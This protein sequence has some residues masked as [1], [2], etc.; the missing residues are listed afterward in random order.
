MNLA[1]ARVA[2]V[3]FHQK[4]C[5]ACE[6]YLPRFQKIMPAYAHCMPIYLMDIADPRYNAFSDRHNVEATPTTLILYRRK[7]PI[8]IE[9]AIDDNEI[10]RV[11]T[12]A[13]R[14]AVCEID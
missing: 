3:V 1:H 10:H 12:K 4:D 6:D 2:V 13:A 8:K 11:L 9:G 5:P 7:S 14:D